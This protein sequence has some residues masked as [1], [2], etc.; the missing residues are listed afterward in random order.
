VYFVLG[1]MLLVLHGLR[2]WLPETV[3]MLVI[4]LLAGVAIALG[5][6]MTLV[7]VFSGIRDS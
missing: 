3:A 7:F 6:M 1:G 4:V 2:N 5:V